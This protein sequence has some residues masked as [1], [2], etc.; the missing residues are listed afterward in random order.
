MILHPYIFFFKY[1]VYIQITTATHL[2]GHE[3]M[4]CVCLSVE[5]VAGC[6]TIVTVAE[7]L[8][9]QNISPA[10]LTGSCISINKNISVVVYIKD[11]IASVYGAKAKVVGNT[12]Y[13]KLTTCTNNK[14]KLQV[15]NEYF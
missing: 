8:Y 5:C 9:R 15:W 4:L 2:L 3:L 11:C 14:L 6:Y 7:A 1:P 12:S 10:L 13:K